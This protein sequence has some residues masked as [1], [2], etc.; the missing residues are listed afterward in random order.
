MPIG[1]KAYKNDI[2]GIT[3]GKPFHV[4]NKDGELM[5]IIL[6][7]L[8]LMVEQDLVQYEVY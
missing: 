1:N 8:M 4:Q 3:D 6:R 5:E 2:R 7:N